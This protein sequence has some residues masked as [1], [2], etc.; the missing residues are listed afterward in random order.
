M[1][2]EVGG[3]AEYE[4]RLFPAPGPRNLAIPDSVCGIPN[5]ARSVARIPS[6]EPRLFPYCAE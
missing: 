6:P 2:Q 3:I 4:N 1:K 5:G